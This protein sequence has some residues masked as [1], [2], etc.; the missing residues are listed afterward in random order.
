MRSTSAAPE[1]RSLPGGISA[2]LIGL[3]NVVIILYFIT[4][5]ETGRDDP[6]AFYQNFTHNALRSSL[7][8]I[9][10]AI[11][12]VLSYTVLPVVYD[13]VRGI[14]PDWARFS[15]ILGLV[16]YTIQ[17]VWA[18]T[19]TRTAPVLSGNYLS[20]NEITRTAILAVG[21]PQID[22]DGWF[23]FGGPGTWMIIVSILAMYGGRIP[24]WHG[25][26]GILAGICAWAT[27]FASFL[28]F[29]PLNLFASAGGAVVYPLWFLVLGIRLIR[30]LPLSDGADGVNR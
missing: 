16:G 14:H 20:G 2:I 21:L 13:A 22:P 3:L 17:G 1:I 15:T 23:S 28:S 7:P 6:A 26:L 30:G 10:F 27:V 5:P 24:K 4:A 19:L 29:E 18:I 25:A 9:V 11:T 8:W 12:A